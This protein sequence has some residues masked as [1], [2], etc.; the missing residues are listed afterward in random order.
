MQIL[1]PFLG[2]ASATSHKSEAKT[3]YGRH[4]RYVST[5][6]RTSQKN[7]AQSLA[8]LCSNFGLASL[9]LQSSFAGTLVQFRLNFGPASPELRSN[10]T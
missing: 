9:E 4:G 10:F 5:L 7:L 3:A 6:M 1:G 8:Q 2:S